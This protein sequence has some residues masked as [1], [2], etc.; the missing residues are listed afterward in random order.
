MIKLSKYYDPTRP[1]TAAVYLSYKIRM[2][3]EKEKATDKILTVIGAMILI[4][5]FFMLG[6]LAG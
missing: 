2:R 4:P 6:V 5:L 3:I 1:M